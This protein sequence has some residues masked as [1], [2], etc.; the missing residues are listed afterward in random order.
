LKAATKL[1]AILVAFL[2]SV[3][4]RIRLK[5]NFKKGGCKRCQKVK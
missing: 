3:I 1:F 4:V 2:L 5:E